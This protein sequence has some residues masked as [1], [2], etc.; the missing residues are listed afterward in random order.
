MRLNNKILAG[1][2]ILSVVIFILTSVGM[3]FLVKHTIYA[4]LNHH[5]LQHKT[6]ITDQ[7]QNRPS[8]LDSFQNTE[9]NTEGLGTYEW[10][11]ITKYDG[12]IPLH[13]NFFS[14]LDTTRNKDESPE[15]YRRLT[16]TIS[17][18]NHNYILRVYEEVASWNNISRTILITI[19]AVLLIWILLVYL[20][21]Q[22]AFKRLL[23][24]F[25]KTVETLEHISDPTHLDESFPNSTTYEINV[26]NHALNDMMKEIRSSFEDQK[27]FLQNASHELLT[28]LSIIRQKAEKILAKSDTLDRDTLESVHDIQGTAVRLSRLSNALLLISRIENKQFSLNEPIEIRKISKE[29][30]KELHDFISMKNILVEEDF[31]DEIPSIRGNKELIR[32]AIYN[33]VQNAI[34]FS[35]A[36]STVTITTRCDTG[37][38]SVS[39]KDQGPGIPPS[40]VDS[41]FDRFKKGHSQTTS[42]KEHESPGLGL[43]IVKSIC[44]L[45]GFDCSARNLPGQGAEISIHF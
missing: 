31:P 36:D 42:D 39:V 7:L 38:C 33:I 20:V 28:P 17:V 43:S 26:L 16:T 45:H 2:I 1:N 41:I 24:P 23:A 19:L 34:K 10:I 40:L 21:N 13:K 12:S 3:Y 15:T 14:T 22:A 44:Q 35:P 32:S 37:D 8:S 6:D 29:V 18:N 9:L 4:E 5:L 27:K 11:G 25:Y 30:I